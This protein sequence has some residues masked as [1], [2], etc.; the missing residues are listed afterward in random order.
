VLDLLGISA[1][2]EREEGLPVY[3]PE[4]ADRRLF[5]QM[6]LWGASGFYFGGNYYSRSAIGSVYQSS[7]LHFSANDLVPYDSAEAR[8][9]RNIVAAQEQNQNT[10]AHRLLDSH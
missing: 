4:I 3:D 1:D 5:L 9:V 10:L 7:T 2:R 6:Q 8:S